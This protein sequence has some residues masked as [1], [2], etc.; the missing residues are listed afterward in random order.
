MDTAGGKGADFHPKLPS[1]ACEGGCIKD[2]HCA[3]SL[4]CFTRTLDSTAPVPGCNPDS[5]GIAGRGYCTSGQPVIKGPGYRFLVGYN[6]MKKRDCS[7]DGFLGGSGTTHATRAAAQLACTER[8]YECG[9]VHDA[10]CDP[11]KTAEDRG[12]FVLCRRHPAGHVWSQSHSSACVHRKVLKPW[13]SSKGTCT[14]I[15]LDHNPA[16]KY[17][18]YCPL[19]RARG[20]SVCLEDGTPDSDCCAAEGTSIAVYFNSYQDCHMYGIRYH[21]VEAP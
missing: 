13:A 12:V 10:A 7:Q 17:D 5:T 4:T 21:Q 18:Y 14:P 15:D 16:T 1:Q 8:G 2:Q 11:K 20:K 9:G 6:L 19:A 3:G